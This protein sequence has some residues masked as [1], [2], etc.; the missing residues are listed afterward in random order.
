MDRRIVIIKERDKIETFFLE[1]REA[2][3]IRIDCT[4]E[5]HLLGNIYSG[6]V[7]DISE[8][9]NA[10]FIDVLPGLTCYYPLS[11]ME[12]AVFLKQCRPGKITQDDLLLV[13]ISRESIKTKYPSVTTNVT[14][15]GRYLVLTSG[16]RRISLSS[17]ISGDAR[18]ELRSLLQE[19]T[20][21]RHGFIIR[22]NAAEAGKEEILAEAVRL[23]AEFGDVLARAH[24]SR[25]Q[26]L[27]YESIPDYVRGLQDFYSE[28]LSKIVTDSP[29]IME[30]IQRY[31]KETQLSMPALTELYEN[32]S[33]MLAELY[34]TSAILKHAM[35]KKV[36]LKSGGY[37]I[38]ERTETL[39][40]IDV[41][42]GK[43]E[44]KRKMDDY[45]LQINLEA[46]KESA[47]QIRL[48]NLSG[49]ILIDF[50]NLRDNKRTEQICE[51]L[52][53]YFDK[54]PVHTEVVDVTKLQ[55]VEITRKKIRKPLEEYFKN[56]SSEI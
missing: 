26:S 23:E 32:R 16:D 43:S 22:T 5:K 50:I 36:W 35:Q 28:G 34:S 10:A 27:L 44:A 33:M 30:Q 7:K 29:S 18:D 39:T 24:S 53:K 9:M 21:D 40:V 13:Q 46:A 14:I 47:R 37:L 55:L 48:R 15:P 2:V 54:D 20:A 3:E 56:A 41:N 1:D 51:E 17:K 19:N 25:P 42:T 4:S 31:L 8:G 12:H 49:I 6:R 52:C 11:E 38:I 45:F